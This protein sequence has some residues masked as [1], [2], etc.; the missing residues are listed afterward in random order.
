MPRALL[1]LFL[2]RALVTNDIVA[3]DRVTERDVLRAIHEYDWLG[4]RAVLLQAWFSSY[5]D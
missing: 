4:P 3:W 1:R 2:L 5:P